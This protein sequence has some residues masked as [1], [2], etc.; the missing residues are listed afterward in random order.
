MENISTRAT[1]SRSSLDQ[2]PKPQVNPKYK[3][4][5]SHQKSLGSRSYTPKDRLDTNTQLIQSLQGQINKKINGSYLFTP[6]K[7]EKNERFAEVFVDFF[8]VLR[9]TNS[10]VNSAGESLA[11]RFV[12]SPDMCKIYETSTVDEYGVDTSTEIS[13][14]IQLIDELKQ[15]LED[16]Y[17]LQNQFLGAL[18]KNSK[19]INDFAKL[20]DRDLFLARLP[21]DHPYRQKW[22]LQTAPVYIPLSMVAKLFPKCVEA[23]KEVFNN[24][25][26]AQW[27]KNDIDGVKLY[28]NENDYVDRPLPSLEDIELAVRL[29]ETA[30]DYG[31]KQR[32]YDTEI[33]AKHWNEF[34]NDLWGTMVSGGLSICT[35]N[36]S[37][38]IGKAAHTMMN[39]LSNQVDPEGRDKRVQVLKMFGGVGLGG[40]MGGN[41]WDLGTS[42]GIDLVELAVRDKKTTKGESSALTLWGSVLKGVLT[43]DQKKLVCQILGGC[44]AEAVNQLPETDENTSLERRI[45]R[46]LLT[47]SDVQSHFIKGFVDKRFKDDPKPKMGGILTPEEQ[48][49]YPKQIITEVENEHVIKEPEM[50]D[51][52]GYKKLLLE[53]GLINN[54]LEAEEGKL[55][56]P[57]YSKFG[58]PQDTRIQ[59]QAGVVEAEKNLQIKKDKNGDTWGPKQAREAEKK[60]TKAYDNRNT[61]VREDDVVKSYID[62]TTNNIASL[63]ER[64]QANR[65]A[66][67]VASSPKHIPAP[68]SGVHIIG[69]EKTGENHHPYYFESGKK[70]GLGKYDNA[71]DARYISGLFTTVE[72][73][74]LG[75]EMQCFDAQRQL[76]EAGFSIDDVPER[77]NLSMPT[78]LG[79]DVD[80]NSKTLNIAGVN[81]KKEVQSYLKGVETLLG[82]PIST[83]GLSKPEI[84]QITKQVTPN[85][86]DPKQHGFFYNAYR[87][88]GKGL[89]WLDEHGVSLSVN[90]NISTDL[91]KTKPKERTPSHVES[92]GY[93]APKQDALSNLGNWES[94]QAMQID[95]MFEMNMAYQSPVDTSSQANLDYQQFWGQGLNPNAQIPPS[96]WSGLGRNPKEHV[97]PGMKH[98]PDGDRTQSSIPKWLRYF[99]SGGEPIDPQERINTNTQSL[100][101][102]VKVAGQAFGE[103]ADELR[104]FG[105][106]NAKFDHGKVTLRFDR[107]ISSQIDGLMD[108]FLPNMDHVPNFR[109]VE[110]TARIA[111]DIMLQ[112]FLG[113]FFQAQKAGPL[114]D[115]VL[116]R[117]QGF[118][119]QVRM[120]EAFQQPALRSGLGFPKM[121]LMPGQ[122]KLLAERRI[123]KLEGL[124][125]KA[126]KGINSSNNHQF[127]VWV[128]GGQTRT[129]SI[130][131]MN[132]AGTFHDRGGLT[133]AGRALDKHGRRIDTVFP[134]AVGS[135]HE[136][137]IQ[138]QRILDEILNHPDKKIILDKAPRSKQ[139]VIDVFHPNGHGARF[140]RDG[141]E[142][143]TFLEP[144]K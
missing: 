123:L 45:A 104:S 14:T 135:V 116:I 18:N 81:H 105:C 77:P 40:V 12:T 136:K 22:G 20:E 19:R 107:T 113:P 144:N 96:D 140:S 103:I 130:G 80:A 34:Q 44:V 121:G 101:A 4:I 26:T 13:P 59:T 138:G 5:F 53:E 55:N 61:A 49:K 52:E 73:N 119:Q 46:A 92:Y 10:L 98:Y 128:E 39:V 72:T 60:L 91:Y 71:E 54:A 129:A 57:N 114:L 87:A 2:Y 118:G 110:V 37:F 124:E 70:Q 76:V 51:P 95:Q 15:I 89:R 21:K 42:L 82:K 94:V 117:P 79:N 66:Q 67:A 112:T 120:I 7:Q 68:N 58:T 48:E 134:E 11:N 106:V 47:N 122:H 93:D 27:L 62:Q 43:G 41:P 74:K 17:G 84:S 69:N 32:K 109:Y 8:R 16:E 102:T 1:S 6:G 28:L 108:Q 143:I 90:V 31:E 131:E 75:L 56:D 132:H 100:V 78:I 64:L 88:P 85:I 99:A 30:K 50:H 141:K 126:S 3:Q 97:I 35:V 24:L 29:W 115:R 139:L 33:E 38:V 36:P 127:I 142:F 125:I 133:K 23:L 9:G 137:N 86:K 83:Q 63:T 25:L 111:N 65:L